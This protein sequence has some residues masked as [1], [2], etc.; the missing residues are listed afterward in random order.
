[1]DHDRTRHEPDQNEPGRPESDRPLRVDLVIEQ[2]LG[3]V[4]HTRN[5]AAILPTLDG[6]IPR[7]LPVPFDA[8]RLAIPGGDNWTLRSGLAARRLVR[9]AWRQQRPDAMFV[10]TQVPAT[11][12]GRLIRSV[13]TVVSLDA[14]PRQY[15][16]LGE[17]YGHATQPAPV[18]W[19]KARIHGKALRDAAHVV[20]WSRWTKQAVADEFGVDPATIAAIAPGVDIDRWRGEDPIVDDGVVRILFVGGDLRRKGGDVLIEAFRSLRAD[21]SLPE[22]EL[23]LATTA[24]DVPETDGLTVHRGLQPNSPELIRLYRHAS[25]F[26]LPTLGDCLPMVLAEAAAV[27]LPLVSTDVGAI[28]E[29]VV[30][31]E[32]GVLVRPGDAAD[33]ER[34]L[35]SLITDPD[36]RRALGA[37]AHALARA[38][39]DA[40]TNAARLLDVL[41]S[42]AHPG[43]G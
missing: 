26:C 41:R 15:D 39:H 21:T 11:L 17:H 14:T 3:H 33:V 28:S 12:M 37:G 27:G 24:T 25:V 22:V 19:L 31:D 6:C 29:I 32:T 18:E 42:V 13:P 9:D 43:A 10:H 4:T 40:R 23:H 38:E 2:T 30:D 1:M 16:S 5:L 7:L 36:R 8:P 35:R 34:A 20:T